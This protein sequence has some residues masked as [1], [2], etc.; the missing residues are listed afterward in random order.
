MPRAISRF[1]T[2]AGSWYEDDPEIL[3]R[4]IDDWLDAVPL[5]NLGTSSARA[6]IGPHAGF[7]Y[8]GHVMAHAYKAI[9]VSSV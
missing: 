6:I 2:H 9:D 7:R 3:G 4:K 5:A 8:C 1:H